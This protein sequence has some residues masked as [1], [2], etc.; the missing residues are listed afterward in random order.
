MVI[1][2]K[3]HANTYFLKFLLYENMMWFFSLRDLVECMK[4]KKNIFFQGFDE[5]RVF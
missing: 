3:M 1:K 4:A 5:N 2:A